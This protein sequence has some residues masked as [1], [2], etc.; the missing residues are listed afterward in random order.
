MLFVII[1]KIQSRELSKMLNPMDFDLPERHFFIHSIPA[2]LYESL[3]FANCTKNQPI[4]IFVVFILHILCPCV[5]MRTIVQ[6]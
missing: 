4:G 5:K 6:Q 2:C 1:T 3:I